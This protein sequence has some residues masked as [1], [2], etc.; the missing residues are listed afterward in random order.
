MAGKLGIVAG[1]GA[2]PGRVLEVCRQSE[3]PVF[4]LA[5]EGGTEPATVESVEHAWT[6]FRTLGSALDRLRAAGV[7]ELVLVGPLKRP[8]FKDL[9]GDVR[10]ARFLAR[11]G[12]RSLG[13]DGLL[14]AV[15]STLEEEGFRVSGIDDYLGHMVA[16]ARPYGRHR[17]SPSAE[18]DLA[19]GFAV[20]RALGALDVGQA[21]VVRDGVVLGVEAQEGTDALL[22]RCAG[23][24]GAGRGGVL[25]KASK[26]GQERRVDLP[27]IGAR[28]VE[29][30]DN[31]GLDGIAIQAGGVLVVDAA[32]VGAAADAAG[33]FVV[34]ADAAGLFVV[35]AHGLS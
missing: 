35:G 7:D 1:S 33:L 29:G 17:P 8:S 6:S 16:E 18:R 26:P 19:Q 10:I 4:M 13:D 15:V 2:L 25:V 30:A 14:R 32:E 3:R 28:T 27:V 22:A 21:A 24:A 20:V 31:A 12:A 34:G 9:A 11:V 5:F 23:L